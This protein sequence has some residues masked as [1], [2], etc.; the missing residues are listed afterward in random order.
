MRDFRKLQIW[1]K[2]IE[3]NTEVYLLTKYMPDSERYGLISQM[4]RAAVGIPSNIA[5]GSGRHS[6]KD[7][8]HFLEMSLGSAYE[9][10]TQLIVTKKI[11]FHKDYKIDEL[12]DNVIAEEKM[13]TVFIN[14]LKK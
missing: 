6:D 8:A 3:I 14:K 11:G 2:G 7:Y 4:T 9:L 5:D 13:L 10:E 1:S 12:I